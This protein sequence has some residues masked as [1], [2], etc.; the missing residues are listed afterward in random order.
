MASCNK[1]DNLIKLI[2]HPGANTTS[3]TQYIINQGNHYCQ[4]TGFA[5]SEYGELKFQVKFDSSAIYSTVV[6]ENQYDIN[7]LY[8]FSDNGGDHMQF[9]ARIG[10]RWSEGALRLFGY[11]HNH[12]Q[13]DFKEVSQ[14]SIGAEHACSIAVSGN[15][16]VFTVDGKSI[17]MDRESTTESAKGYK[18][19]PYFG[20]DETAPHQIR[21]WIKEQ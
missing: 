11:T 20:G 8:G 10:W 7:K 1:A 18:L 3:F 2:E 12:G 21:I 9:S 14:V 6:A 17:T 4:Q 15:S 16:Y 19:F 13:M 5:T